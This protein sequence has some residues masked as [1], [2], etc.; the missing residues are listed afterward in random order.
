M[1]YFE[2]SSFN[3]S[4]K[5]ST[6]QN[7]QNWWKATFV[8][9]LSEF[10]GEVDVKNKFG[11]NCGEFCGEILIKIVLGYAVVRFVVKSRGKQIWF[12][13]RWVLCWNCQKQFWVELWR[14]LWWNSRKKAFYVSCGEFWFNF[15]V[16]TVFDALPFL[17]VSFSKFYHLI[18]HKCL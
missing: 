15:F 17:S 18:H 3:K 10:Y 9:V 16:K 13:L 14:V 1:K 12:K 11:L 6:R 4:T 8:P 7:H 5:K 2:V